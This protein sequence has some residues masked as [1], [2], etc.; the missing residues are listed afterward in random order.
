MAQTLEKVVGLAFLALFSGC[1][2]RNPAWD[3]PAP[4]SARSVGLTGSA[5][6]FDEPLER[7]L[8]LSAP[9]PGEIEK[10]FLD[11][12]QNIA[13]VDVSRD[14]E[15]MYV[16]TRGVQPRVNPDDQLPRLTVIDG[17]TEPRIID[18]Y[19][20]SDPLLDLALD[21]EGEWLVAF[22]GDSTV[23]NP[24]ELAFVNLQD[25]S[26]K[27]PLSK[28]IR[29]FGGK[30]ESL[31]FTS[32]LNV[33]G[34]PRRFL[35]VLTGQDL[36]LID[37]SDLSVEEIT[38]QLPTTAG[39]G[40]SRPVQAIFDDGEPDA[41]NDA[42][43]AIRMEGQSDVVL[44]EFSEPSTDGDR[45]FQTPNFNIVDVGGAPSSIS[46]VHTDG[47]LRVAALVPSL[48]R[49]ALID[50]TTT[51]VEAVNF[52]RG[53]TDLR[54][55]TESVN[56]APSQGDVA[57]L[58]STQSPGAAFWSLG[59]TSGTPFRSV[60][61][62]AISVPVTQLLD[63]PGDEHGHLKILESSTTGQF[64]VL[65]LEKRQ[66]FPMLTDQNGFVINVAPDG[67][68]AWAFSSAQT[69]EFASVDLDDLHPTSLFVK[70]AVSAVYDIEVAS[71]GRSAMVLHGTD[72]VTASTMG[73]T[74]LDAE[75]PDS[76]QTHFF[77]GL[78][79]GGIR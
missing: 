52:T 61:D 11:V 66:T 28:T 76:A 47:G 55:V 2:E 32:E 38:I 9:R 5:A 40:P 70:P 69:N 6:V 74:V 13:D 29:S 42:R 43:L 27:W 16:L 12:G 75:A 22:R 34:G 49:A 51:V 15:R 56:G 65:D 73:V 60:D 33:P 17:G 71:G 21:P 23:T 59:S 72:R 26:E 77:G 19:E 58:W 45:S 79:L 68:R 57:L 35:I 20:L 46:F 14:K 8:M 64:F 24:N 25:D 67:K 63:V 48:S 53:Y 7:V 62:I 30:P 10:R 50:P 36:A 37:L 78:L 44:L 18:T 4:N 1:G 31:T 41:D 54:R 3:E 39:G